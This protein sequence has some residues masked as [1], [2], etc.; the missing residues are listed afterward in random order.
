MPLDALDVIRTVPLFRQVPESELSALAQLVHERRAPRGG[1]ILSQGDRGDT[2]FLIRSGQVK[3]SVVAE[4]GREVILSVLGSGSFFGELALLD[5]EPRSAHVIAMEDT[6][7]LQLRREDFR[8]RLTLSPDLSVS[9]LRE[10]SQRLRRADDTIASLMLLDV[11]G[12]V[13]NLLLELARE[14]GGETGTRITRRLTHAS[15]GQ[16]VGA[17]R[18]T[19][20]RTMRNLVIR[21][22]I[23]VN[24]RETVLLDTQALRLAAQ[25]S[26]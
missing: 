7:L 6:T 14:E 20:S 15:L 11:N 19:V 21:S 9:L 22:V 8:N 26:V 16:M 12:R 13:A 17:S 3:V 23:S 10:L 5:D 25:R 4:D 18:E 1:L 24:R 2:L